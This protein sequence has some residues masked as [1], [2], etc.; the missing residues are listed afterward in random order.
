MNTADFVGFV[1]SCYTRDGIP[2]GTQFTKYESEADRSNGKVSW[3]HEYRGPFQTFGHVLDVAFGE[4]SEDGA[5]TGGRLGGEHGWHNG[6]KQLFFGTIS[7]VTAPLSLAAGGVY[8]IMGAFSLANGVD[9]M[10]TN[11]QRESL[12]QQLVSD[13]NYKQLIADV[14]LGGTVVTCIGGGYQLWQ[15]GKSGTAAS[16]EVVP[17]L[18][19][20][21]NDMN[22]II[23]TITTNNVGKDE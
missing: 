17:T 4:G 13:P 20:T 18:L 21:G 1:I 6:G 14:K 11:E 7:V 8:R 22:S 15:L 19:A 23:A 5:N 9:D 16:T 10:F 12:T 3:E 2:A